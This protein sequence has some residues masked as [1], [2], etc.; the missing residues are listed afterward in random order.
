[1]ADRRFAILSLSLIKIMLLLPSYTVEEVAKVSLR[2]AEPVAYLSAV[3]CAISL[4]FTHEVS[5]YRTV[6]CTK[7]SCNYSNQNII[8]CK[9]EF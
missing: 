8:V 9:K 2:S 4:Y 6:Y 7:V 5:Q 1:M 3:V